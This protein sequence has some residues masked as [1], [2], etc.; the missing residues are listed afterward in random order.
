MRNC[1]TSHVAL[2]PL[3]R[4]KPELLFSYKL[5]DAFFSLPLPAV[6]GLISVSTEK[7]DKSVS[8]VESQ[9]SEIRE[10]MEELKIQLYAR[11]GKSINL[12]TWKGC[13]F[14]GL[15]KN[16][17]S[18]TIRDEN[19]VQHYREGA[20]TPFPNFPLINPPLDMDPKR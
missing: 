7:I 20:S 11:F 6:Q 12:E 5:G 2:L 13:H 1:R 9:L 16:G 3:T 14:V 19:W 8:A 17:K 4:L 15:D 10:R 18:V